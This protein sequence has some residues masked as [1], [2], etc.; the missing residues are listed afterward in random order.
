MSQNELLHPRCNIA[1]HAHL[2]FT[3]AL[4]SKLQEILGKVI[5]PPDFLRFYNIVILVWNEWFGWLQNI[6]VFNGKTSLLSFRD[7]ILPRPF[8]IILLM[9]SF[10][11]YRYF[12]LWYNG[13]LTPLRVTLCWDICRTTCYQDM[14][15][16]TCWMNSRQQFFITRACSPLLL[17]RKSLL[18]VYNS[19]CHMHVTQYLPYVNF[20]QNITFDGYNVDWMQRNKG[21]ST[22]F[23]YSCRRS[24]CNILDAD[25]CALH[26]VLKW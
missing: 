6:W 24:C 5:L 2:L 12:L 13:L 26:V 8:P 9:R 15:L 3:K 11:I 20:F 14:P 1:T 17:M 25:L 7:F 10:N 23:W 22:L 18:L 21:W 16:V 19:W 4:I